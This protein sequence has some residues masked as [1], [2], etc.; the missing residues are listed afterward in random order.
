LNA[1]NIR[2]PDAVAKRRRKPLEFKGNSDPAGRDEKPGFLTF[3][4]CKIEAVAN[5]AGTAVQHWAAVK[6]IENS[7][8]DGPFVA[9][10]IWPDVQGGP[11]ANG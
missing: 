6:S 4:P 10:T 5:T 8:F 3:G 11:S 1:S 2:K 7:A 9:N